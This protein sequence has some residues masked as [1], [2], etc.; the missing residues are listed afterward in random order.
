M[1][2]TTD[3]MIE[4]QP[5]GPLFEITVDAATLTLLGI[6]PEQVTTTPETI[7]EDPGFNEE[8]WQAQLLVDIAILEAEEPL[9]ADCVPSGGTGAGAGPVFGP[10]AG[11]QAGVALGWGVPPF[12]PSPRVPAAE[13]VGRVVELRRHMSRL[14]ALERRELVALTQDVEAHLPNDAGTGRREWAH[15]SMLAELAV[16][17]RVSKPTMAGR[18]RASMRPVSRAVRVAGKACTEEPLAADC[19]PSHDQVGLATNSWC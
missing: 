19:V 8:A 2:Q 3:G 6:S 12:D 15:R 1:D 17:C 5:G 9:A 4:E 16:A 10:A 11:V 18:I 7:P 14:Q 13:R